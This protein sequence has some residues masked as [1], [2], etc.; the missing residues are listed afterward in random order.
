MVEETSRHTLLS[1]YC[2][3]GIAVAI[4]VA[5]AVAVVVIL[6]ADIAVTGGWWPVAGG[7]CRCQW[8]Y[9]PWRW[10]VARALVAPASVKTDPNIVAT[11]FKPSLK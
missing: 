4:V 9:L 7:R 6:A 1:H 10:P 8:P 3:P 11:K 2:D 5:E